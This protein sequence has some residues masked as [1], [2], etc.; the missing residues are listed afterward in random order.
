[1]LNLFLL[2]WFTITSALDIATVRSK[3]FTC[4]EFEILK[5]DNVE[6]ILKNV[7]NCMWDTHLFRITQASVDERLKIP[8]SEYKTAQDAFEELQ[9][10]ASIYESNSKRKLRNIQRN[11]VAIRM[12]LQYLVGE[13]QLPPLTH[14]SDETNLRNV[15]EYL[16]QNAKYIEFVK[17]IP[18]QTYIKQIKNITFYSDR[19]EV[20]LIEKDAKLQAMK[21]AVDNFRNEITNHYLSYIVQEP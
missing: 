9:H 5:R 1:M 8:I 18:L 12:N 20:A 14:L 21:E 16:K 7:Y 13:S 15:D 4:T 2:M 3:L 6:N 19:V 17:A 11:I 10:V